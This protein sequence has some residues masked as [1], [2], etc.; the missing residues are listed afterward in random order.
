MLDWMVE[1]MVSYK[2]NNKTYFA[3]MQIMDRYFL[4]EKECLLPTKLHIL[5][6]QSMTI[7]SK[8]E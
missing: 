3:S 8:M 4:A 1:V 2:F 7:A 5:G 6:V